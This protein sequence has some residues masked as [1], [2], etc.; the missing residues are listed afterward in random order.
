MPLREHYGQGG[1]S[2]MQAMGVGA[3]G[4]YFSGAVFGGVG[5]ELSGGEFWKGAATGAIIAGL[6]HLAHIADPPDEDTSINLELR[7]SDGLTLEQYNNLSILDQ[8]STSRPGVMGSSGALESIGGPVK[9]IKYLTKMAKNPNFVSSSIKK[10][11]NFW[12]YT[13][14]LSGSKGSFTVYKRYLNAEGNTIKMFHD[15]YDKTYRFMHREIMNG[16]ERMKIW[17]NGTRQWFSK[18]R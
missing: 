17:Y 7:N 8:M 18:W 5:A 4:T 1:A 14:K 3:V 2:G 12:E 9:G 11:G 13:S 6:N 10:V 15:T 16:Q